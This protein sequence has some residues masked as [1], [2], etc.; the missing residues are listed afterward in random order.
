MTKRSL[1]KNQPQELGIS[2]KIFQIHFDEK[3]K[4][5]NP[6]AMGF[7]YR[8]ITMLITIDNGMTSATFFH[9]SRYP[10]MEEIRHMVDHLIPNKNLFIPL[11]LHTN[12]SHRITAIE[13]PSEVKKKDEQETLATE[14]AETK[15][16]SS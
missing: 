1:R 12:E 6:N 14:V 15:I 3:T 11:R 16:E 5:L 2:E 4:A 8:N 13:L 9:P 10:T 7:S